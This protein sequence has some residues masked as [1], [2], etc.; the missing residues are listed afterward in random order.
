MEILQSIW[1]ALTTENEMIITL[2][3][4]PLT[5]IEGYISMLLFTTILN[6]SA[7]RKQKIIYVLLMSLCSILSRLIIPNPYN[8]FFNV[9]TIFLLNIFIFKISIFK[10]IL[11]LIIPFI[12]AALVESIFAKVYY[13]IFNI[14]YL[15]GG[16]IPLHRLIGTLIVYFIMYLIYLLLK[17]SKISIDKLQVFDKKKKY[18]LIFNIIFGIILIGMQIYVTYFYSSVLPFYIVLLSLIGL[19]TYIIINL[20]TIFTVAKLETTSMN[21]EEEKLYNKTLQILHDNMRAFKHD[22]WNIIQGIGGYIGKNDM[23]G[24]KEYYSK[25]V[26]DCQQVNNLTALSPSVVN[27]PAIYN[28]L[29]NKYHTADELGIKIDLEVFMD[30]N[31]LNINSYELTR[32]LG[33]LMNN[34]IEASKECDEKIIN[35]TFRKDKRKNMQLIIVEN[36]YKDKEIDTEKIYEKGFSTKQGNTGLGLWEIRQI[37][38]KHNNLNLYTTKN[39]EFFIQQFEIYY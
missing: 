17:Y 10:G 19:L 26:E 37:L 16:N 39:D 33:I 13:S 23:D 27:N 38:K 29:A 8:T 1:T 5:F 24:L 35:V 21:L 30:L 28:V 7:S 22:F 25:L 34:A 14:D 18:L 9:L 36:T 32:I 6:I 31:E 12:T 11:A 3:S 20:N 2:I 15:V 4:I